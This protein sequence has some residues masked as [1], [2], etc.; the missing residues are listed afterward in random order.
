MK[1]AFETVIAD[2]QLAVALNMSDVPY[3]DSAGLGA[4][5]TGLNLLRKKGGD[6]A[7]CCVQGRVSQLLELTHLTGVVASFGS[8]EAAVQALKKTPSQAPK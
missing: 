3:V 7:L 8:E 4:I 6:M 5:V 2:G 1:L